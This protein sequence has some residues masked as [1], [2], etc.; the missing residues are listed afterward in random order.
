MPSDPVWLHDSQDPSHAL[1]QHTPSSSALAPTQ[2]PETH[3]SLLWQ[4][5]P[6]LTL[7]QLPATHC[8]PAAHWELVVQE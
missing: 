8:F 5:W 2:K 6:L 7:P 3:A 1:L 4:T